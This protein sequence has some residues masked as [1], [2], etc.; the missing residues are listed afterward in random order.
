M[1]RDAASTSPNPSDPLA[2][3][4]PPIEWAV[5]RKIGFVGTGLVAVAAILGLAATAIGDSAPWAIHTARLL[6]VLIGS[7]TVGAA[8]SMRPDLWQS[9]AV[10]AVASLLAIAGTPAHWD[11][12]RLLF[13]ALT[14]IA[15][16]W[17]VF[18]LAP[19]KFRLPAVSML[20]LFHFSGI[21][22]ATTTPPTGT[23]NAPW[24]TEQAFTRIFN[25][26][27]QFVYLRNA[28]HFYSPEPGPASVLVFLLTT[29]EPQDK[30]GPGGQPVKETLADI[31][32][33]TSEERAKRVKKS[34]WVVLPKRPADVKDPLGLTYYRR[35]SLTE[36]LARGVPGLQANTF[37]KSEM[38]Q[39]RLMIAPTIPLHPSDE[40]ITQYRLPEPTVARFVLPSYA[41]HVILD[42]TP[43]KEVAAMTTVKVYRMQHNTMTV[44]DFINWRKRSVPTS[45]YHPTWYRPFFMGEFNARGDLVNPQEPMLYWLVPITARPGGIPPGETTK[46]DFLDYMSFHALGPEGL[47]PDTTV[48]DLG[49]PK[50]KDRV[51]DWNQL[52]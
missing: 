13:G 25:P 45:P 19:A 1:D 34:E 29:Y 36:Q 31:L 12:F 8:V 50:F 21:F 33:M 44:D 32:A 46:R 28:Y 30:V 26:Y 41:S 16:T 14:A 38:S 17:T 52:R 20:V 5:V 40:Q 4:V 43:N 48:D 47:G 3:V 37:E 9:W 27:L 23:Y 49:D 15:V 24:V 11:S 18:R 10:G 7:V 42:H 2:E 22:L 6:L 39:R 51:F 35:L